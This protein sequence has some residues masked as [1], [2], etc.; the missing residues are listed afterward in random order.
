VDDIKI[1]LTS[2]TD[3]KAVRMALNFY[4]RAAVVSLKLTKF[5]TLPVG[6]LNTEI[7]PMGITYV[8]KKRKV[9]I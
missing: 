7:D 2:P 3:D 6:I 5:K 9:L 8:K 4:Q 1:I